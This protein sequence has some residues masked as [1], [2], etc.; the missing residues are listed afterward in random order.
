MM[1][2]RDLTRCPWDLCHEI[3]EVPA[4]AAEPGVQKGRERMGKRPL[5]SP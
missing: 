3:A 4:P 2:G 1:E 5:A